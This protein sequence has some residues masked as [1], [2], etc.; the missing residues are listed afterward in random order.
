LITING[1]LMRIGSHEHG[2]YCPHATTENNNC[3]GIIPFFLTVGTG[4]FGSARCPVSCLIRV[5]FA[6]IRRQILGIRRQKKAGTG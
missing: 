3:T 6:F 5:Y 4:G 1:Q 2:S